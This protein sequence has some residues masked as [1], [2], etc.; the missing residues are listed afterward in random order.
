M[1]TILSRRGCWGCE[2]AADLLQDRATLV[3]CTGRV[4]QA[5]TD[6]GLR[7]T[8]PADTYPQIFKDGTHLGG[9]DELEMDL[10]LTASSAPPPALT[11]SSAP[12]PA[13]TASSARCVVLTPSTARFTAFPV[14]HPDLWALYK[15]AVASFWT[16]DEIS[17]AKDVA[18]FEL[19][20]PSERHFITHVLAFFAS[21]DGI[22]QENL[23]K[24]F[25]G[26]V[27]LA[28]ARQFFS[29][30]IFN[31]AIHN[32]TYSVLIDALVR[33]PAAKAATFA[34]ITELPAVRDK[35]AW[36][37]KW[38]DAS[39]PFAERLVAFVCVEGILFSGSF[40]AVYWLKT[41]GL[42][43]GLGLSNQF[44][45]RDEGLHCEFGVALYAK[46]ADKIPGTRVQEIVR[47]AV[48]NEQRFITDAVPC[49]LVGMNP[50]SMSAYIEFVADRLLVSLG[51]DKL[52]GSKNPFPWMELISLSGKDNFF[53]RVASEYQKAGVL[54]GEASQVFALD[55]A[56]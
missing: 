31:E 5:A 56:F 54:G 45:S 27:Q 40:C 18:E 48:E 21:S 16:A 13:S 7:L 46:L 30:Q 38:L 12:P 8:R 26:E 14:E 33:D 51:A 19:L 41:R 39:R 29:Y 52:F 55:E 32:E 22:V 23:A 36:A 43:P 10:A 53:E 15:R 50:A 1:Y 11:A 34:A 28:E 47:E 17:L 37:L 4:A 20:S 24:N 49:D 35:A 3:E 44:I 25:L 6:M 42:M 2:R 9:L